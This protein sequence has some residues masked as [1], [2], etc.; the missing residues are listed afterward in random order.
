MNINVIELILLCSTILFAVIS[1]C[2]ILAKITQKKSV[3]KA[4]Q[5]SRDALKDQ[6]S[7]NE[8]TLKN[9]LEPMLTPDLAKKITELVVIER[10]SYK[11]LIKLYVDYHPAAIEM[12]PF[13]MNQII[14]SYIQCFEHVILLKPTE[15]AASKEAAPEEADDE[16]PENF[17]FEALIEQLRYEKQDFANKYKDAS[18]LLKTICTNHKEQ[19]KLNINESIE[20]MNLADIAKAFNIEF[21][22]TTTELI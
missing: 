3:I 10:D 4:I 8:N 20:H 1:A 2:L 15:A 18:K 19:L 16:L 14:S 5:N 22:P 12:M 9:T 6:L 21:T 7:H 13:L 11:N 17:Q